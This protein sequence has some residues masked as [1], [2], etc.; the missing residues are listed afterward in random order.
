MAL[1]RNSRRTRRAS[2]AEQNRAR[3]LNQEVPTYVYLD[4]GAPVPASENS[5]CSDGSSHDSGSYGSGSYDSSGSSY[6]SGGSSYDSGGSSYSSDSGSSS[7]D[8][9]GGF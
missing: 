8:S 1:R 9:G 5:G 3:T 6:S 2:P 7:C 4:T